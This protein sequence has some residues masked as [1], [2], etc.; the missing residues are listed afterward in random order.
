M[1]Q[2]ATLGSATTFNCLDITTDPMPPG[3]SFTTAPPTIT[4]PTFTESMTLVAD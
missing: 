3:G 2:V 4:T 1:Q